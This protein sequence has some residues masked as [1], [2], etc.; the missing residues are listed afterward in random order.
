MKAIKFLQEKVQAR[1]PRRMRLGFHTASALVILLSLLSSSALGAVPLPAPN[2][3]DVTWQPP[4]V[5][6][7]EPSYNFMTDRSLAYKSDNTPCVVYGGDQLYYACWD[8]VNLK[9]DPEAVDSGPLAGA[10]AALAFDKFNYPYISYYDATKESLK[11]A[12]NVGSGWVIEDIDWNTLPLMCPLVP[13]VDGT[14]ATANA[15]MGPAEMSPEL[16]ALKDLVY[17]RNTDD[18]K[19]RSLEADVVDAITEESQGVGK[20]TS[21]AI[22]DNGGVHISYYNEG[23]RDL[24]YAFYNGS[25]TKETVDLYIDQ[26]SVGT[27]TSI[28]TDMYRKPHIAYMVEKYDDLRYAVKRGGDWKKFPV[29]GDAN[30]GAFASLALEYTG[31]GEDAIA[32]PHISYLDFTN[33]NL[34]YATMNADDIWS[35]GKVDD[36]GQVG[37]YTSIARAGDG[38]LWISY[39]DLGNGNLK[40]ARGPSWSIKTVYS[41][42]NIGLNTSI[43]IDGSNLPGVIFSSATTN[44]LWYAHYTGSVWVPSSL[45]IGSAADV[46][47]YTSLDLSYFGQPYIGYRDETAGL[48]KMAKNT[49]GDWS[50]GWSTELITNTVHAGTFS[51]LK[52][53][54]DFFVPWVGFYDETHKDLVLGKWNT[55][56]VKWDHQAIAASGDMGRYVSLAIDSKGKPHMSYLDFDNK[57]LMYAYQKPDNSWEFELVDSFGDVGYFTSLALNSNDQPYISY[58]DRSNEQIKYAFYITPGGWNTFALAKVGDDDDDEELNEAYSSIALSNGM[59]RIAYYDYNSSSIVGDVKIAVASSAYPIESS[60]SFPKV[61]SGSKY[62]SMVIEEGTDNRHICYYDAIDGDLE[63]EYW[64]SIDPWVPATLDSS[65]DVGLYCSIALNGAGQPAISYYDAYLG[66]LKFIASYSELLISNPIYIPLIMK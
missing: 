48:L 26:G 14:V 42:G 33:Y 57:N 32:L 21:I 54:D 30:V 22:D 51:S 5:V 29:D 3:P 9:W 13:G 25:W 45:G 1:N 44:E 28:A 65:G 6:D 16:R 35:G 10:Y 27:Y 62:V 15:P 58:Y 63:Y 56:D 64:N 7:G 23:C 8:K 17:E 47:L 60:W 31:S 39:Y 34:K 24:K 61:I 55:V 20:Y 40:V 19:L 38:K 4:I 41:D 12:Y 43:A 53:V 66:N 11:W 50:A 59:P 52:L 18:I 36:S 49:T 37:L 46:G 2:A